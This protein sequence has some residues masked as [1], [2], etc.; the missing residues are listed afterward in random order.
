MSKMGRYFPKI[1]LRQTTQIY[2]VY[3]VTQNLL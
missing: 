3:N 2:N 1:V